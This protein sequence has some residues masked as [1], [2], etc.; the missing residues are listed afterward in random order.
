MERTDR[1]IAR[2]ANG[3]TGRKT[4]KQQERQIAKRQMERLKKARR[5][6]R[7]RQRERKT[8]LYNSCPG[9]QME[10]DDRNVVRK[11]KMDRQLK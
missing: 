9:R 2:E 8:C 10:R 5:M 3:K 7:I 1:K 6:D 4:Q 11:Q